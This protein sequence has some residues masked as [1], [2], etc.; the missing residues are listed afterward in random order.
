M[1]FKRKG[2]KL[3]INYVNSKLIQLKLRRIK[4]RLVNW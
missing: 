3:E 1:S 4:I 2:E